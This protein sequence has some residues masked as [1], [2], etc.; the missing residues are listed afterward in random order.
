MKNWKSAWSYLPVEWNSCVGEIEETTQKLKIR[1]NING[2]QVRL[3][4]TNRF[5]PNRLY[6]EKVTVTTSDASEMM[7]T[8]TYVGQKHIMLEPG[9][10]VFSDPVSLRVAAGT[11][12]RINVYFKKRQELYSVCQTWCA[13]GWQSRF[14]EGDAVE[15]AEF[16]GKETAEMF[17]FFIDPL[18][19]SNAAA[20]IC[21]I[22]VLT[23]DDVTT[24]ACFGDSITH[25][26][27]Y[28]DPLLEQLYTVH[29]GKITLINCGFG[30]NRLLY[31][32]CF[33]PNIPGNAACFGPA[34]SG[35]FGKDVYENGMAD[36]V[37]LLEGVNDC[38]HGLAFGYPEQVP[39]GQAIADGVAALIKEAHAHG[40]SICISTIMP[41]G[42]VEA[43]HRKR[44]E[45]IRQEANTAIRKV[46]CNADGFVDLDEWMCSAEDAQWMMDGM[47]LGDGVH[48]N[49][50]GGKRM[51][52]KIAEVI[53]KELR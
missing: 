25:M 27:F 37:F 5:S 41:F 7:Q 47:H 16:S 11:D 44:G 52:E 3:K 21:G 29:P 10:E 33:V 53:E 31:D 4:F 32:A 9:E 19:N 34:G 36:I 18:C 28:F 8:V 1:N 26:S 40:S 24:V 14:Q 48:P 38:T 17:P 2:T 30:G 43:L 20:G 39:S 13:A 45:Q 6:M 42:G 51:A 35:R 49:L 22:Q 46:A 23:D 12:L 50:A 15:D